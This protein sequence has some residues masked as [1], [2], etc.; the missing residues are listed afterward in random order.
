MPLRAR[1]CGPDG[2]SRCRTPAVRTRGDGQ[3]GS[4]SGLRRLTACCL[5]F[6]GTLTTNAKL[7]TSDI[8]PDTLELAAGTAM[9]SRHP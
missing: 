1:T 4:V 3:D 7:V 9:H 8:D 5:A 2:A 6:A